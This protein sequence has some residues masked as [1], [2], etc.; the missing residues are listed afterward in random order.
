M[1][2]SADKLKGLP[3]MVRQVLTLLS[4][5]WHFGSVHIKIKDTHEF[6]IIGEHDGPK[7]EM[8]IH[9]YR[10]ISRILTNGDIG[11][12]DGYLAKEW[13]TPDLFAV[14][15]AFSLN[16]DRIEKLQNG[17]KL[18]TL[19]NN[20]LHG[21]RANTKKGAKKNI[22]AHYDLGNDFY[23]AWLDP[24]MTYSAAYFESPD[25]ED[26]AAAQV[27]KYEA[28]GEMVGLKAGQSILEIGCGWGGFAEIA[29]K[30]GAKTTGLTISNAQHDYAVARLEALGLGEFGDI[31]LQDYRDTKDHYDA[32]VSIEMFEAVGEAYWP[33]YFDVVKRS[34]KEGGVAAVQIITMREDLFDDY[35]ARTDF[36]QQYVFP[37]GMLPSVKKLEEQAARV[38]LRLEV[39]RSLQADYAKTLKLWA[40]RFLAAWEAGKITGFDENF[41][42]LWMFY[43][44]YC[45]AGFSTNRTDVVQ[46]RL[47]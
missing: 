43:L 41:K 28:L 22:L 37:G 7:A 12:C 3:F 33:V 32:I 46:I 38:G 23:Q 5:Q 17:G 21:L 24:T 9:D 25:D 18:F 8:I 36:I 45:Y 15:S 6:D 20:F 26:L 14:L 39:V 42:R 31:R 1:S 10:M 40:D 30:A 19:I 47:S 29:A 44:G 27:R 4:H 13:D 11:F 16:L 34:L 2:I 35:R